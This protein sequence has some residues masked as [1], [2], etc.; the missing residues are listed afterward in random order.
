MV[1]NRGKEHTFV[2]IDIKLKEDGTLKI[3]MKEYIN[4]NIIVFGEPM[5]KGANTPAKHNVFTIVEPNKS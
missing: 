1:V 5:G 2:G 4:E 3:L